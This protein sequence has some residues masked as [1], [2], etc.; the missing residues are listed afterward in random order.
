MEANLQ[1]WGLLA[2]Q[3]LLP[4]R[5]TAAALLPAPHL[6]LAE[7]SSLQGKLNRRRVLPCW[8]DI[9]MGH[10]QAAAHPGGWLLLAQRGR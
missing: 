4:T 3:L 7:N 6:L 1:A 2:A 5:L 8:P 10:R 9:V